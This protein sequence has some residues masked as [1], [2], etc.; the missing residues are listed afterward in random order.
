MVVGEDLSFRFPPLWFVLD[1]VPLVHITKQICFSPQTLSFGLGLGSCYMKE[2]F[3][4][5][6]FNGVMYTLSHHHKLS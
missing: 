2:T 1:D 3:Y 4:S 5:T 6:L